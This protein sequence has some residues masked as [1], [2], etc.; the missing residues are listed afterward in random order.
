MSKKIYFPEIDHLKAFAALQVVMI[1]TLSRYKGV[2][3]GMFL[4]WDLIHFSVG[5]FVLASGFLHENSSFEIRKFS[6]AKEYLIK[7]F[8]RI[9]IPYYFYVALF[10]IVQLI[11]GGYDWSKLLSVKYV[12][13]TLFVLGGVGNTW[14]PRLFISISVVMLL[15]KVLSKWIKWIPALFFSISLGASLY[16]TTRSLDFMGAFD[17]IFGWLVIFYTGRYIYRNNDLKNIGMISVI[18]FIIAG[19]LYKITNSIGLNVSIFA[20]KYPPTLYFV[21]YNIGACMLLNL[22]VKLTYKKLEKIKLFGVVIQFF[23]KHSYEMFFYHL[24]IMEI[25][26]IKVNW[27]VDWSVI[28]SLTALLIILLSGDLKIKDK[29]KAI[30]LK[31]EKSS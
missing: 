1:H 27:I 7:K 10:F 28:I 29:L 20:N 2:S 14:I 24:L 25:Y 30:Y 18:S 16:S 23:S 26:T 15:E 17:N 19:I 13:E 4:F 3:D 12:L 9:I 11:V 31:T 21:A 22:L 8:K 6:D 5:M